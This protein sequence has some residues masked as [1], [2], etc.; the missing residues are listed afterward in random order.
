[1]V[2]CYLLSDGAVL[3]HLWTADLPSDLARIGQPTLL[4]PAFMPRKG[5]HQAW[6]S[7][8]EVENTLSPFAELK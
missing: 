4:Y 8:L 6:A 7:G 5:Y 1:M 2:V 3:A